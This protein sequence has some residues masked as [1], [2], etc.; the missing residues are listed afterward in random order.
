M[1]LIRYDLR[2]PGPSTHAELY[3]ACLE[4]SAWADEHKCQ[5]VVLSEH[6]GVAA[7]GYLSSPLI[8][9]AAI[10]AR[11]SRVQISLQALLLPLHDPIRVAE[12]VAALDLL[13]GGRF[14]LTVALGYRDE[15]F[16][17][18]GVDRR[19]RAPLVEEGVTAMLQ[20]W[21]GEPFEY[22]GR[23]VQ[24]TPR[25]STKPHPMLFVG[26]SVPAGAKRAARLRLPFM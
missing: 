8:V 6:H 9:A 25:P 23:R 7:D 17:M 13:S 16:E 11:T 20:A 10:A 3:A 1:W 26:G 5:M 4:Q 18:F 22:R 2:A 12:D 24:V 19:R 14:M 15:E 21:T